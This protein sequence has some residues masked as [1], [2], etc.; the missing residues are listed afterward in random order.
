MAYT[1]IGKTVNAKVDVSKTNPRSVVKR[2]ITIEGSRCLQREYAVYRALYSKLTPRQRMRFAFVPSPLQRDKRTGSV[3]IVLKKLGSD[4]FHWRTTAAK[5]RESAVLSIE[6]LII[7]FHAIHS[8]EIVHQ[9]GFVHNDLKP[10]N[11]C[12][13]ATVS[14]PLHS[15]FKLYIIDFGYATSAGRFMSF[16]KGTLDFSSVNAMIGDKHTTHWDDMESLVYTFVDIF[17]GRLKWEEYD[18]KKVLLSK[19]S[20]SAAAIC[21][22]APQ[23]LC[24]ILTSI[25]ARRRDKTRCHEIDYSWMKSAI[26]KDLRALGFDQPL[27]LA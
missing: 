22:K 19:R 24:D 10:E 17:N 21:E 25:R 6:R 27:Y 2:S 1:Q 3:G 8:L 23:C 15:Q 12:V 20:M 7:L 18:T 26:L 16:G 5:R 4:L 9:A 11:M 14:D 13:G